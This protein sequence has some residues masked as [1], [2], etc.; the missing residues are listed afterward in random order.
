MDNSNNNGLPPN[1][2][3]WEIP[4]DPRAQQDPATQQVRHVSRAILDAREAAIQTRQHIDGLESR[5]TSGDPPVP[6]FDLREAL[7]DLVAVL[8][9]LHDAVNGE[10]VL[11]RN[12]NYWLRD[13]LGLANQCAT[14]LTT[15]RERLQEGRLHHSTWTYGTHVGTGPTSLIDLVL[16]VIQSLISML[17]HGIM[18]AHARASASS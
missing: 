12:S 10:S 9:R 16:S 11:F 1:H 3:S 2:V 18:D 13:T 14:T 4:P 6:L 15:V 8:L 7:S 5:T 17:N